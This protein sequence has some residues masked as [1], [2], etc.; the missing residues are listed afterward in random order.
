MWAWNIGLLESVERVGSALHCPA[1][2]AVS[3][4]GRSSEKSS[5][6]STAQR[7]G[8]TLGCPKIVAA[9]RSA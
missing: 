3:P 8:E 1:A 2:N 9:G 4:W 7:A 5:F 6:N